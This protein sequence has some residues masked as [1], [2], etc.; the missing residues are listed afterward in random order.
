VGEKRVVFLFANRNPLEVSTLSRLRRGTSTPAFFLRYANRLYHRR[1]N[2]RRENTAG[3]DVLTEDWDTL[4]IL[5]ACRYDMFEQ[6]SGLPGRLEHRYSK[7]SSTTEFLRANLPGRDL[8]DTV[9]VTANPQ[10]YGNRDELQVEF[11]EVINIWKEAGWDEENHTV[12]PETVTEYA[13]D[14]AEEYPNK[15][16][17]VHYIQP[18]YPFI[19]SETEF[20][21][22]HLVAPDTGER[23]VWYQ[24]MTGALDIER[25]TVW[26]LYVE[27]LDRALPHVE[28]LLTTVEGRTVVTADHGNM[29]GERAFPFPIREW[30]HPRG[31]YTE[32]LVRVPWL[33]HDNGPRREV[34]AGQPESRGED[35][36]EET[37]AD[38]LKHLGYTE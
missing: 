1:L 6:H 34:I 29:V 7:G 35:I 5:D 10:F 36:E 38:R 19:G 3:T 18:H 4:V 20:D 12:L 9:Y 21:K 28:E 33:I 13:Q 17:L 27:N 26:Q 37:V 32:Q 16:L 23:N 2:T 14:A 15:R 25:E 31:I 11:H 30:G 22:R 24:L 8:R